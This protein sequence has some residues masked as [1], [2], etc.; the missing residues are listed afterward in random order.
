MK[1]RRSTIAAYAV[2]LTFN[3]LYFFLFVYVQQ[4]DDSDSYRVTYYSIFYFPVNYDYLKFEYMFDAIKNGSWTWI[5]AISP[6]FGISFFYVYLQKLVPLSY[7]ALAFIINN[8]LWVLAY[9]Y[10]V[11]IM[12]ASG[13]STK[14]SYLFF[15][16][17][18]LI[19]YSQIVNKDS[20]TLFFVL[21]LTYHVVTKHRVRFLVMTVAALSVRGQMLAFSFFLY[22]LYGARNFRRRLC[23]MYVVSALG[24]VVG[25]KLGEQFSADLVASARFVKFVNEMNSRYYVGNLLLAPVKLVQWI[26][27]QLLSLRFITPEGLIDLYSLRDVAMIVLLAIYTPKLVRLLTHVRR[28]S[29]GGER[30]LLSAIFAFIL[31]W[32]MNPITHQRYLFP[33]EIL[34]TMLAVGS[35]PIA[36]LRPVHVTPRALGV[37]AEA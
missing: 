33:L 26:Y 17:P 29:S 37:P 31:T 23:Q 1:V 24:A 18:Q 5:M 27:D 14:Y 11:G 2:F 30:I 7:D 22:A 3:L 32:L 9:R 4:R 6:N 36:A 35:P 34:M 19:Y 21:G 15:F 20:L 10:A 28:Y 8:V 16:N 12:K 25:A 13:L